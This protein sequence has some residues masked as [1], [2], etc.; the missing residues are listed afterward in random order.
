[1]ITTNRYS[2]D[3]CIKLHLLEN[4]S[5]ILMRMKTKRSFFSILQN[6]KKKQYT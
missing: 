3:I 6:T 4:E 5:Q 2:V 1:M